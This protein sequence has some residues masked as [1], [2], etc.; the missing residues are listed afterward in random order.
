MKSYAIIKNIIDDKEL[1]SLDALEEKYNKIVKP[2][3]ISK[4][5]KKAIPKIAIG[6]GA[7]LS[8]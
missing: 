4:T 7:L 5:T 1:N 6:A 2:G 8:S 3:I